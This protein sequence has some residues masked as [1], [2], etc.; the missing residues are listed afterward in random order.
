MA[1][2]V[3]IGASA[4]FGRGAELAKR[5]GLRPEL[6]AFFALKQRKEPSLRANQQGIVAKLA[7]Q[8]CTD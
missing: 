7:A 3:T 1:H 6:A 8:R 4:S 2:N 5:T